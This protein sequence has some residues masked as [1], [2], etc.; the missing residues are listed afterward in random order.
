[1]NDKK[2]EFGDERLIEII[3]KNN[4]K[5]PN[6]ILSKITTSVDKHIHNGKLDDDFTLVVIKKMSSS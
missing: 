5:S 2:E 3:T 1:M 6:Q 4:T